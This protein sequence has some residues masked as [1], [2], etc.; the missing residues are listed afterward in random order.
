MNKIINLLNRVL[1]SHGTK[2]KKNK[3]YMYWSP[4]SH[5]NQITDKYTNGK[6]LLG[7]NMGGR[8]YFSYLVKLKGTFDESKGISG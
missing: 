7:V 8:I 3:R 4:L 2:L 6:S 1:N 5:H